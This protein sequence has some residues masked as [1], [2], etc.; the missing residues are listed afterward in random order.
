MS[1]GLVAGLIAAVVIVGIGIGVLV[2]KKPETTKYVEKVEVVDKSGETRTEVTE[3][4][5]VTKRTDIKG[6]LEVVNVVPADSLLFISAVDIKGTWDSLKNSDFWKQVV[7]LPVWETANVGPS[8]DLLTQQA[9][10]NLGIELNEENILGLFGQDVGI[11]LVGGP[12][13][14]VNPSLL[15]VAKLD[16]SAGMGE[17]IRGMLDKL[18]GPLTITSSDYNG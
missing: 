15:I 10:A 12:A 9:S 18:K 6:R 5:S 13:G 8:L 3:K 7:G 11:A 1:K 14:A 17:K 2:L 16:M 4:V